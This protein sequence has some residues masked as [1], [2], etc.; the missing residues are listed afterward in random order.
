VDLLPGV[1]EAADDIIETPVIAR[2]WPVG[3]RNRIA[4]S[5]C[6]FTINDEVIGNGSARN[7]YTT[8]ASVDI[9]GH[10]GEVAPGLERDFAS[11]M[12]VGVDE[13]AGSATLIQRVDPILN[14]AMGVVN[15]GVAAAGAEMAASAAIN[16]KNDVAQT[17]ALRVNFLRP[18]L[19]KDGGHYRGAAVRNGRGVAVAEG[20]AVNG[21]GSVAVTALITAY[22]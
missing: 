2:S 4:L 8:T 19:S 9:R 21:D 17:M 22:R 18:F 12:S 16:A 5:A 14:N 15:G 20:R 11:M 13:R 3:R 10:A 7:M 6:E 1:L